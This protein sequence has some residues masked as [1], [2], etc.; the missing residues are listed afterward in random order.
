MISRRPK[1]RNIATIS[2]AVLLFAPHGNAQEFGSFEIGTNE[3]AAQ[4]WAS[5]TQIEIPEIASQRPLGARIGIA[6]LTGAV[7][8][9]VS[10][11]VWV[12]LHE[13]SHAVVAESVG[14]N[15]TSFNFIPERREDGT[16]FFASVHM[17][18]PAGQVTAHESGW[19]DLAP[20]I[21]GLALGTLGTAAWA[22]NALPDDALFRMVF[23]T[24]QIGASING[25]INGVWSGK[26]GLD[27][28]KAVEAFDLSP[29]QA[30]LLRAALTTGA[31]INLIPAVDSIYHS[32]MGRS[33]FP[34]LN[35]STRQDPTR[36]QFYPLLGPQYM[37]L[38]ATF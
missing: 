10:Y 12:L 30:T 5:P 7:S 37:G 35:G 22:A 33:L 6:A 14:A 19:I 28:T 17:E 11:V 3:D 21:T 13:G 26:E 32:I 23:A 15:V 20:N 38:G 31:V 25:G 29:Q 27:I 18:Y 36:V 2:A 9:A 16:I 8:G 34:F 24:F 4:S 1:S